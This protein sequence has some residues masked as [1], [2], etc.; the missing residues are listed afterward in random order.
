MPDQLPEGTTRQ[1]RATDNTG[2]TAGNIVDKI[3]LL[4]RQGRKRAPRQLGKQD[5]RHPFGR[6]PQRDS[7]NQ[8][9]VDGARHHD[10]TDK[11]G[12]NNGAPGK[13][14]SKFFRRLHQAAIGL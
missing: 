6:R 8:P 2:Q 1:H 13:A 9:H 7:G 12:P 3:D 11:K 10:E 5:D 4:A 14:L